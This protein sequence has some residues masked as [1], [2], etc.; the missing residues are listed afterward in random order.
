MMA[1]DL[2]CINCPRGCH[3][4]VEELPDGKWRVSGN[5]CPRGVVYAEQEMTDPRRV[6]TAAVRIRDPEHPFVPVRTDKAYPKAK[7]PALLKCLYRM[8]LDRP[9]KCG[10]VI[11]EN[12][13]GTGVNV[14]VS[15]SRP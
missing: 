15:E 14:I 7:I 1:K 3:L 12:A 10:D 13:D 6:V 11:L 9:L 5:R 8:T 2:I 4:H